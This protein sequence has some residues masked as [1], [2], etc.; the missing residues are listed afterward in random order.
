MLGFFPAKPR[1]VLVPSPLNLKRTA[2]M[3]GR[4]GGQQEL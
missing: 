2:K 4:Q 3:Q 1:Q